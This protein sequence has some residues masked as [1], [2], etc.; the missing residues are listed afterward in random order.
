VTPQNVLYYGD[1]LDVLRQHVKVETVDLVYLDPPF[2][3][4][5]NYNVLFEEHGKKA[6]AQIQA[7]DDTW[8]WDETASLSLWETINEIGGNVAQTMLALEKLLPESDML[9]YLA[10]MAPRLVELRRVL[11]STGSIFLHC[12]PTASHYLKILMDAVFGPKNFRNEIVWCY[13]G[14]GSPGIRQFLRKHDT[15]F[16]YSMGPTWTFNADAVRI[17]HAK[18]TQENYKVG[19]VGSGFEGA[20]HLIHA[21]GKIPEDWWPIAIA[22]RGKEYLGYPTQKP[23]ALLDRIIRAASNDDDTVLDPFCGCGTTIDAAQRLKRRWVG[24]DITHLAI[25]LIKHRLQ[26][27]YG[28]K[29]ATTYSVVGEPTDLAGAAQLAKED[30]WQFQAWALGLVGARTATSAKK[31]SD[32]GIDGRAYFR[33]EADGKAKQIIL[34]VKAGK[35]NS[36]HVDQLRGVVDKEGAAIGA[37]ISFQVPT[38]PMRENAASAG[39]YVSPGWNQPYPRIQLLSVSDLLSKKTR[40]EY[41]HPTGATFK[42]PPKLKPDTPDQETLDL[43]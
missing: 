6:A 39:H 2:K 35:T 36:G 3:S 4:N 29:I 28:D 41:P 13:F 12:D 25:G 14:P 42:K 31:G 27:T 43:G 5:K 19:L 8:T 32:K 26:D 20:D 30:P 9:A 33:D 23:L 24:I 22:P 21:G 11:K 1:N 16:W 10:M 37:L 15:I 7:F 34:S 17:P 38:K 18:K 40:L